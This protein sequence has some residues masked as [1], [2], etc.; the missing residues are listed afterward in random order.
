MG[1]STPDRIGTFF[2]ACLAGLSTSCTQLQE[3]NVSRLQG[4]WYAMG[5]V[6]RIFKGENGVRTQSSHSIAMSYVVIRGDGSFDLSHTMF[7]GIEGFEGLR[8]AKD[9][10]YLDSR[11]KGDNASDYFEAESGEYSPTCSRLILLEY[12]GEGRRVIRYVFY[13]QLNQEGRLLWELSTLG[14][15]SASVTEKGTLVKKGPQE[16]VTH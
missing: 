8:H 5:P 1:R 9:R 11:H 10:V 12:N 7:G 15:G 3:R 13:A 6:A 2:A 14:P 16:E 4:T